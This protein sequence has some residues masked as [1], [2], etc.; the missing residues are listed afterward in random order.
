M[1]ETPTRA[2]ES[3]LLRPAIDLKVT[4]LKKLAAQLVAQVDG[5]KALLISSRPVKLDLNKGIAIREELRRYEMSMISVALQI[6]ANHQSQA[7]KIL[8]VDAT[9]L[10][11]KIKRY[12]LRPF[13]TEV[14]PAADSRATTAM[15]SECQ[16]PA[17]L[18]CLSSS[19]A[20]GDQEVRS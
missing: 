8:G 5:L 6:T 12:R 11:A 16:G 13:K 4:R 18:N 19:S 3:A 15:A 1:P 9:T 14:T 17:L 20:R 7:A 10:N 2:A